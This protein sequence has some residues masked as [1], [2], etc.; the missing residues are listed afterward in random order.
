MAA[1]AK[2]LAPYFVELEGERREM[3]STL[4]AWSRVNSGSWNPDGLARMG[5]LAR[6]AFLA[7]TDAL[8]QEIAIS[9]PRVLDDA[10]RIKEVPLGPVQHFAVR[11]ECPRRVLL[12]GHLDTVFAPDDPFQE[13]RR[14]DDERMNGPGVA[15]M[16]G[17]I[18]VMLHALAAFERS[19]W[20]GEIGWDVL[21]SPDE[22]IGSPGSAAVLA[23]FAPRAAIGLTYEPA[24][25]DGTLAGA[26]KGSGNFHYS[27]A[28]RAAHAGREFEKGRNALVAAA[29]LAL[30]LDGLNGARE[31]VTVNPAV[32]HAGQALNVVPDRAVLRVNIRV[33]NRPA[34]LW[35][36]E[37]MAA[38]EGEIAAL[39]GIALERIGGFNRPPKPMTP[40]LARLFGFVR[41]AGAALDLDIRWRPTGGC[42][43]GNNLWAAGLPNVDTLGVRGG[44]IHSDREF[45][46]LPSLVERAK[47]SLLL[48]AAFAAGMWDETDAAISQA[49]EG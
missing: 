39:D 37:R 49:R 15:D 28:G 11:P 18:L 14:L 1:L 8:H 9:P 46:I 24:L 40:R 20:A 26:R 33:P 48:L 42:C 29:R 47:L 6:E 3:E 7:R 19:R 23:E 21:L 44:H 4:E 31:G 2:E 36:E 41:E 12:T 45:V 13:P 27:I 43:E 17:G 30:P 22:E 35:V 16:K 10:G 34:M 38:I 5:T 25:A 32:L